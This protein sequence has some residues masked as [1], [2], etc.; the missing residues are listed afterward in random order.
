MIILRTFSKA[1]G[2]AGARCGAI[3]ADKSI[4]NAL[5]YVQLPFAFSSPAQEKV[6]EVL[7]N[8]TNTF[9]SWQRI[10]KNRADMLEE[11]S[12]LE[13]VAKVFRVIRILL[14]LFL[15][16]FRRHWIY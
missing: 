10:K 8:P 11:L 9:A 6:A 1:W 16:T 15:K 3:I 5:R 14:C 12:N 4:I 7:Q 2:L 13:G